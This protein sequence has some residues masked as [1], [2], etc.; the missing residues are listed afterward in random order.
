[1][2]QFPFLQSKLYKGLT[3]QEISTR[4]FLSLN[5]IKSHTLSALNDAAQ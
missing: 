1:M 4:L 2:H 5:T 3:N